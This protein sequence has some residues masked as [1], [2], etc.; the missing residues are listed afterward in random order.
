M[1]LEKYLPEKFCG[2]LEMNAKN[3]SDISLIRDKNM[4][5]TESG[6]VYD[7]DCFVT[8][9]DLDNVIGKM[10]NG[11]LYSSQNTLKKG[12]FTL[13]GGHRVGVVG[14]AVSN[15]R[16]E[17]EYLRNITGLNIRISRHVNGA[18]DKIIPHIKTAEGICNTL[19]VAPPGAGKTTILKDLIKQLSTYYRIG[20]ADERMEL[21]QNTEGKY[22][23][24]IKGC[25]KSEGILMLLRSMSPQVIITDEIG[26]EA[27]EVVLEKLL[28]AGV[29][30]IC[31]AHGYSEKDIAR[32]KVFKRLVEANVFEK[33]IV[34]SNKYGYGTI[35]KVI[36]TKELNEL[37]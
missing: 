35:E 19:I 17:I 9:N 22:V 24:S 1:F 21:S 18:A 32:R 36:C 10:C 11:S 4:F 29:K 13:P 27:D 34:I 16:D 15:D 30:M 28:N 2:W 6:I 3:A 14:D 23:F 8:K 33:I 37:A 25:S 12:F 26:T 20:V 5:I 31:T 7:S